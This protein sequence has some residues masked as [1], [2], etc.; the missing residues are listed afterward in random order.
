MEFPQ[1]AALVGFV[2]SFCVYTYFTSNMEWNTMS[3]NLL[4]TTQFPKIITSEM[5]LVFRL[6]CAGCVW[7]S[8][9]TIIADRIGLDADIQLSNN[10]KMRVLLVGI[11]RC[12]M[13]TVWSWILQG[14]YFTFSAACTFATIYQSSFPSLYLFC[15]SHLAW[16]SWILFEISFPVAYLVSGVVTY[17]LIP[18]CARQKSGLDT[19]FGPI[20][21]LM[22]NANVLFMGI[23][24]TL[25]KLH[26]A[27]NHYVFML[28]YGLSYVIFSWIWHSRRGYF[29]YFF[30]DYH[31]KGAVFWHLGLV[32]GI[33]ILFSIGYY[34]SNLEFHQHAAMATLVSFFVLIRLTLSHFSVL[35]VPFSL[36]SRPLLD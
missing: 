28:F 16:L 25:N 34:L 33:M 13:F 3:M 32:T 26:F 27:S 7:C 5:L 23:E 21:L 2:W 18:N 20:A 14:F 6:F 31:R 19:F 24:F 15:N 10:K 29:Y 8:V 12:T 36:V 9:G 30:L 17:V 1:V 35:L 11:E 22:H 4:T